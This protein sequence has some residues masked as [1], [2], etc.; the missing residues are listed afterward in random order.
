MQPNTYT[1]LEYDRLKQILQQQTMSYLGKKLALNLK[2]MTDRQQIQTQLRE[3]EEAAD[4]LRHSSSLPLPTMEG[5]EQ[6]FELL[7]KGYLLTPHDLT[8]IS[9]FLRSSSQ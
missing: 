8:A 6:A 9:Q 5:V 2:P 7:G 1:K 3:V 4:V